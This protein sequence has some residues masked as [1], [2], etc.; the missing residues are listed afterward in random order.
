VVLKCNKIQKCI[1]P[2]E[3]FNFVTK[4]SPNFAKFCNISLSK[5]SRNSNYFVKYA[6]NI[7]RNFVDHPNIREDAVNIARSEKVSK[8][9][10]FSVLAERWQATFST[11]D[12]SR[13]EGDPPLPPVFCFG[14]NSRYEKCS[15]SVLR[16]T[17]E[18]EN[19]RVSEREDN[20]ENVGWQQQSSV[21]R[22]AKM[23][24]FSAEVLTGM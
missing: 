7:L 14:L 4:I 8:D 13:H 17:S 21:R 20:P 1:L 22:S 6:I 23:V 10:V 19:V 5:I 3:T 18:E 24:R 15:S 2:C 11:M 9:T 12:T 16:S